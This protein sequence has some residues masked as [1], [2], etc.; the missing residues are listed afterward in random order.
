MHELLDYTVLGIVMF[1]LTFLTGVY[2]FQLCS[3]DRKRKAAQEMRRFK[4]RT[5]KCE[6]GRCC[7]VWWVSASASVCHLAS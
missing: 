2:T 4:S 6:S 7:T 5:E 3:I 1:V